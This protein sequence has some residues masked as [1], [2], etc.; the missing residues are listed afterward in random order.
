VETLV[1]YLEGDEIRVLRML[2]RDYRDSSFLFVS[3]KGGPI[4]P[5]TVRDIIARAG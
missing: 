5:R 4:S 3:Q 1:H 2:K